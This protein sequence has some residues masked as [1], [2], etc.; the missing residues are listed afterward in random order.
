MLY[1]PSGRKRNGIRREDKEE[2][3]RGLIKYISILAFPQ[4]S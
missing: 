2:N 4:S 1:A 3:G